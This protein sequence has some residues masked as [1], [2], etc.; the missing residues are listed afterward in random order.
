MQS[1]SQMSSDFY[2]LKKRLKDV[3][4]AKFNSDHERLVRIISSFNDVVDKL[5]KRRPEPADWEEIEKI[6]A[7]LKSYTVRHFSAEEALFEKHA[8]KNK[9]EHVREH[10]QLIHRLDELEGRIS[11]KQISY[12]VDLQFFLMDWLFNH[13]NRHDMK[14][15]DFFNAHGVS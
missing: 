7:E 15:K 1:Q 12:A 3:G 10:H 9:N 4:V 11:E 5:K 2:E 13:I 14:Y 8:Y 6:F